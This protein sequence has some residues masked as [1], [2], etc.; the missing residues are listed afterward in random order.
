M[1]SINQIEQ[2]LI[3]T[4]SGHLDKINSDGNVVYFNERL[5]G[6]SAILAGL[7]GKL[8]EERFEDWR[9]SR[10]WIDDSLLTKVKLTGNKISIWG[11]MIWGKE[12]ILKQWTAP[13]YFELIFSKNFSGFTLYTFLFTDA[14]NQEMIY[15]EF[16]EHR[17]MWDRNFYSNN[18]WD[19]YERSWKYVIKRP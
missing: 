11:I 16:R 10:K 19:P 3:S 6:T 2:L 14:D 9:L 18:L 8:L 4:L 7:L 1:K 5:E 12:N 17:D 15:E 13:F